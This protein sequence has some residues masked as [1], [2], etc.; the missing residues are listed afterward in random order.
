MPPRRRV[1]KHKACL[2]CT[3]LKRKCDKS[4]PFCERCAEMGVVCEY[5]PSRNMVLRALLLQPAG[6]A[7]ALP[8]S[9]SDAIVDGPRRDIQASLSLRN[10]ETEQISN[11]TT[12]F[13]PS[14]PSSTSLSTRNDPHQKL[15]PSAASRRNLSDRWFL[16]LDTWARHLGIHPNLYASQTPKPSVSDETHSSF[17]SKLQTWMSAWTSEGHNSF[18]HKYL[19]DTDMPNYV[20][21]ALASLA[22]YQIASPNTAAKKQALRV[23]NDRASALVE[24]QAQLERVHV[25]V[26]IGTCPCGANAIALDTDIHMARTQALLIYQYIRLFDGDI[27]SRAQAEAHI[28]QLHVWAT[29]MMES[30]RLDCA[31]AVMMSSGSLPVDSRNSLGGGDN[32]AS[33]DGGDSGNAASSSNGIDGLDSRLYGTMKKS[34]P[35][36]RDGPFSLYIHENA[37]TPCIWSA[38]IFSESVRRTYLVTE[39][40]TSS[41]LTLKQGWAL[42]ST[43]ASFTPGAGLWD[44]PSAYSWIAEVR[45]TRSLG[46]DGRQPSPFLLMV[47]EEDVGCLFEEVGP[48]E[49]DELAHVVLGM[50]F[51]VEN[52]EKWVVEK[53]AELSL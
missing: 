22:A 18:T 21:H 32:G 19:Y 11:A 29:Q 33:I 2:R 16:S 43:T 37:P 3:K 51:G 27:R 15:T 30:A 46:Q 35:D 34:S 17:L 12:Q 4:A 25:D 8:P 53:A 5:P 38:W 39:F 42:P 47:E 9:P 13:P 50:K 48:S 41:Y 40:M 31:A 23:A 44:A 24:S 1:L 26:G 28:Q 49:V 45:R 14:P 36:N 10:R 20:A 6:P 52:V 7:T